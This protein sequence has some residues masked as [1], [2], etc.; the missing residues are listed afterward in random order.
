MKN[1]FWKGMLSV[2]ILGLCWS[3]LIGQQEMDMSK[4]YQSV[5][6]KIVSYNLQVQPGELV[7][8]SGNPNEL[9]LMAEL[10]VAVA[11]AG[12]TAYLDLSIPEANKRSLMA[13]PLEYLSQTRTIGV[14]RA[15][16]FDCFINLNSVQDPILFFGVPEERFAAWRKGG[17]AE[18]EAARKAHYRSVSLGQT[19]GIP[20]EAYAKSQ[21]ADFKEMT[22]MFWQSLDA[23]YEQMA[24]TGKRI[25][26]M[27]SPGAQVK[28]TSPAGTNL[29]F[30]VAPIPPG[31]NTGKTS[32]NI[33]PSGPASTWL[34][35]GEIYAT[36]ALE[37]ANGIVVMPA[38]IFRGQEILNLKMTFTNG[39]LTD[40]QADEN[41]ELLLK[42]VELSN[43]NTKILSLFDIGL[44]PNSHQLEG[45]NYASWEMAGM[46]T[47]GIGD[48]S[49]AG[50]NLAADNFFSF[51]LSNTTLKIDDQ[52]VVDKGRLQENVVSS[53]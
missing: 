26:K 23:D 10:Q 5:A 4:S 35:A 41:G 25:G 1:E 27:L 11:K 34:P 43:P 18:A 16:N 48:N 13:M 52:V 29:S 19:G 14:F 37:S 8:I 53:K 2:L 31:L 7:M 50:G 51:H 28:V 46:V 17:T 39:K 9:D 38:M 20:T 15:R 24:E 32:D 12:G 21:D 49:W 36:T 22:K 47:L 33:R 42:S 44:N 30:R 3:P 6:E 40:V 45:S